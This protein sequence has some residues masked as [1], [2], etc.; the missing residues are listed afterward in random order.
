MV[1]VSAARRSARELLSASKA[2][3]HSMN[4]TW[5]LA[6]KAPMFLR[7]SNG[8]KKTIRTNRL[9]NS[10]AYKVVAS[11]AALYTSGVLNHEASTLRLHPR[12]ESKRAPWLPSFSDGAIALIEQFLCAYAQEATKNAAAARKGLNVGKRLNAKLMR[13]GFDVADEAMFGTSAPAPRVFLTTQP[14][15]RASK[16]AAEAAEAAAAA[17][18]PKKRAEA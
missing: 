11:G 9:I 17:E 1:K 7:K 16:K 18:Q 5:A 14:P 13:L 4:S 12:G 3:K 15:K 6:R 10:H 2:V 8:T